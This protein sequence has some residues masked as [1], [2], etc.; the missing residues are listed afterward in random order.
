[1]RKEHLNEAQ[2]HRFYDMAYDLSGPT[3]PVA[4]KAF[5]SNTIYS[6]F[7]KQG[8]S[9]LFERYGKPQAER[10]GD[11]P[12]EWRYETADKTTVPW[13]TAA[14]SRTGPSYDKS[15]VDEELSSPSTHVFGF[16]PRK[17]HAT[18]PWV[19]KEGTRHYLRHG[20]SGPLY[21]DKDN[22]GN[23]MPLVYVHRNTG[24]MRL[25]SGHHRATA[26]LIKGQELPARYVIGE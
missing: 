18:Q 9:A 22:V 17:L 15:L 6:L 25:L 19:T 5:G 10:L 20:T 11:D 26:A 12:E 13:Q 8:E 14:K 16:D 7:N 1:M 23:Y 3:N 2:L 24:Q 21:A 4:H